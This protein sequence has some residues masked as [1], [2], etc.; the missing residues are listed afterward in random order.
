MKSKNTQIRREL[1]R[2]RNE[3]NRF[4]KWCEVNEVAY[5][6]YDEASQDDICILSLNEFDL[7]DTRSQILEDHESMFLSQEDYELWRE[8]TG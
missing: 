5:M 1:R 6:D 3:V 7:G 8:E 2:Y 4:K